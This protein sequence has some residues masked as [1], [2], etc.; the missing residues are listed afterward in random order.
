MGALAAGL[1]LATGRSA[2]LESRIVILWAHKKVKR[3][4]LYDTIST[5]SSAPAITPSMTLS[6]EYPL[7][8]RFYEILNLPPCPLS[9]SEMEYHLR[10]YLERT[11]ALVTT[12]DNQEQYILVNKY[13]SLLSGFDV[14]DTFTI[15]EAGQDRRSFL[16][17]A[18]M[19]WRRVRL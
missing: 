2:G 14:G 4:R 19:V 15:R 8:R 3:R 18:R 11:G 10:H 6:T 17:F 7:H 5:M 9:K 12:N 16:D 1:G 13:I